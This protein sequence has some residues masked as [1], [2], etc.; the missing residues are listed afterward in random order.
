M[1]CFHYDLGSRMWVL[2]L[3]GM[4]IN[5]MH[6]VIKIPKKNIFKS[7]LAST[8]LVEAEA[9]PKIILVQCRGADADVEVHPE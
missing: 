7:Q 5:H 1:E 8:M 2:V 3:K 4:L 6:G 9:L